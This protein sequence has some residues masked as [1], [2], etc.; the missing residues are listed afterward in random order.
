MELWWTIC[1]ISKVTDKSAHFLS[2]LKESLSLYSVQIAHLHPYL[3]GVPYNELKGHEGVWPDWCSCRVPACCSPD[4]S[5]HHPSLGTESCLRCSP[6]YPDC[7]CQRTLAE[8]EDS[9]GQGSQ[10]EEKRQ[11]VRERP[12]AA[13]A[14]YCLLQGFSNWGRGPP[15]ATRECWG[16]QWKY[17][18]KKCKK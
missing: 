15:G 6:G 13:Q 4:W 2:Y 7:D 3:M 8:K 18:E 9:W 12:L 1:I 16:C 11:E 5:R 17:L 10:R 14:L